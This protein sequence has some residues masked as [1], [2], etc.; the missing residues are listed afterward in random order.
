MNSFDKTKYITGLR[1]YSALGVL[2]IHSGGGGLRELSSFSNR[3]VDFG[4]YGV[5][6]FFVISAFTICM[7]VDRME[8]FNLKQYLFKRV[9][10][11][12]PLFYLVTLLCFFFTDGISYFNNLFGTHSDIYS[13]I[14]H[15][16]FLNLFDVRYIN[17]IIG[18]EGTVPIEFAY[19]LLIPYILMLFKKHKKI[20]YPIVVAA[21]L[22]SFYSFQLFSRFYNKTDIFISHNL[23]LEKYLFTFIV[24]IAA[25]LIWK[26][27]KEFTFGS[28]LAL[29]FHFILLALIINM[30]IQHPEIYFALWIVVLIFICSGKSLLSKVVFE[31]PI[32][33]YIGKISYSIYLVHFPIIHALPQF[34]YPILNLIVPLGISIAVSSLTYQFI[35]LQFIKIS[36]KKTK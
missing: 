1:A 21:F 24:G 25:Y 5:V 34:K 15:L 3:I 18:V 20:V 8:Q 32:I 11:I 13:L 6:S 10:R 19:Y 28:S 4:K 14:L 35:E 7:S 12:A 23:S 27:K 31:N 26:E 2:L 33:E 9:L 29:F 36:H 22:F 17:N 16:T 30:N